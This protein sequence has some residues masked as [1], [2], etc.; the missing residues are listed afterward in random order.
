MLL[1]IGIVVAIAA[2]F[3]GFQI[4]MDMRS[5]AQRQELEDGFINQFN[6]SDVGTTTSSHSQNSMDSNNTSAAGSLVIKDTKIGTGK[7]AV[8][9]NTVTVNYTGRLD[10]GTVFDSSVG[11]APF[12]F[13][14]G[15]GEVIQGWEMGFQGMKEGGTRTLIIPASLGYGNRDHGPIP[16]G[17]TLTFDVELISVQ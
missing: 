8:A 14:I 4:W 2:I 11:R 1:P 9:G 6:G 17:S 15:L 13:T 3:L 5:T 7:E 12:S 16:A 10:D